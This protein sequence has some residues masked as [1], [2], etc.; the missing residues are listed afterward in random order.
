M[1]HSHRVFVFIIV[2]SLW[3]S[4]VAGAD[5]YAEKLG[6][7]KGSR[8]L[9]INADDAGH[10]FAASQGI[11]EGIEAGIVSSATMMMPTPWV[12]WFR[13]FLKKHP[14]F[15]CGAHI[16]LCNE[17]DEYGIGPLAGKPG[18]PGLVDT[19]G[20]L[21]DG[22]KLVVEHATADEVETEIRAQLDRAE[23]MGL[24]LTHM[25]SHMW[26][27]FETEAFMERYVKIAIE[28]NLPIRIVQGVEG[29]YSPPDW[30]VVRMSRKFTK[31][32]WEAGLPVLDDIH[33][34]SYDWNT[35]DKYAYFARDIRNLKPG[36]T[37]I[38][39]HPTKPNDVIG[40]ITD[41]RTKLYGDYYALTDP[42]ILR[43]IEEE[44]VIL[45]TWAELKERRDKL[46]K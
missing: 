25:D 39:A 28:K 7:P 17:W 36:I 42:R 46:G 6:W 27:V 34:R 32:V 8:V 18:V 40:V 45:T 20:N 21:W 41:N 24:K 11:A 22:N 43:V 44:G 9:I 4:S 35:T 13:N 38:V 33:G 31:R 29:G 26:T 19:E 14:D 16:M 23:T 30:N 5:T 12:L 37:E 15:S 3:L 10:T 2:L 1:V